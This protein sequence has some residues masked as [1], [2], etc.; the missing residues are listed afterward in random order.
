M[1]DYVNSS[2]H[3]MTQSSGDDHTLIITT[4]TKIS[5]EHEFL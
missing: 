4:V 1:A 5:V 3:Y 2:P